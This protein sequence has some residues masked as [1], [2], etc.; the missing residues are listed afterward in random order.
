MSR[1]AE[2]T[3][4]YGDFC[5]GEP[6]TDEDIRLFKT[7]IMARRFPGLRN[8]SDEDIR[9]LISADRHARG[10]KLVDP[11]SHRTFP[12]TQF[13]AAPPKRDTAMPSLTAAPVFVY[14]NPAEAKQHIMRPHTESR[15]HFLADKHL[16]ES[17][18]DDVPFV[19]NCPSQVT[20]GPGSSR[21][22][23]A[24]DATFRDFYLNSTD[25]ETKASI[26]EETRHRAQEN[27]HAYSELQRSRR[28]QTLVVNGMKWVSRQHYDQERGVAVFLG[29]VCFSQ[30]GWKAGAVREG[31]R[32]VVEQPSRPSTDDRLDR[33]VIVDEFRT[34]RVSSSVHA[35]QP[36]TPTPSPGPPP[37]A[38]AKD[39]PPLAAPGPVPRPQGPPWGRWLDRDTNPCLNFQ[40]TGESMQRPLEL[41][42]PAARVPSRPAQCYI[43]FKRSD[44]AF[45]RL[46]V[47]SSYKGLEALPP[48]G[49]EYQQSYKRVNDRLPK[50]RQ[51]LHW[52]AEYRRGIDA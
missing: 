41:C 13:Q 2:T 33:L 45:L 27:C 14:I 20:A 36:W 52:A 30:G 24:K 17:K 10:R 28:G 29:A 19:P 1:E 51:R 12:K 42:M 37:P 38:P 39:Q 25:A 48:I 3:V 40:R 6:I 22:Y 8:L 7:S 15:D 21:P 34:T 35:R 26:R 46:H 16:D 18:R 5:E 49:K 32:K 23:I 31:F 47:T 9:A 43:W 50:G 44:V 11:R 4:K